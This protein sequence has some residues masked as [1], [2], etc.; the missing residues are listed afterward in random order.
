MKTNLR[1][2]VL[3]GGLLGLM[4]CAGCDQQSAKAQEVPARTDGTTPI[5][6]AAD[7]PKPADTKP[8]DARPAE[9]KPAAPVATPPGPLEAPA[10]PGTADTNLVQNPMAPDQLKLTPALADVIKLVQSGV[11]EEV[12]MTY[13]TNSTDIF[14]IGPNEILYLHDLGVPSPII[15][16]LIQQDSTPEAMARKQAANAVQPL[17]PGVALNKPAANVFPPKVGAVP[18]TAPAPETAEVITNEPPADAGPAPAV[19]YTVPTEVQQPVNVSYF[20]TELAPYG[21]WVD[22]PGYGRCWRP[23]VSVWNSAWRPYCDGGRWLWSDCGWYW[24]SDYTWGASTFH[25]GR[26]TC[27]PGHGWLWVPDTC[28]GPSWVSWRHTRSHCAW[29]P[30]PPS[31]HYVAGRGWYH[32]TLSVGSSSE[33]GLHKDAYVALPKSHML[34]RRPSNHYLSAR[35]AEAVINESSVANNY[36]TVNKT[37]VNHGI[38]IDTISKAAGGNIRQVS[39]HSADTVGPRSPR[40]ELL[41][42]DGRTL[43]VARPA[44]TARVITPPDKPITSLSNQRTRSEQRLGSTGPQTSTAS[45]AANN[46]GPRDTPATPSGPTVIPS[47]RAAA[48]IIMRGNGRASGAS[49]ATSVVGQPV[50]GQSAITPSSANNSAARQTA[51]QRAA[52]PA[53]RRPASETVEPPRTSGQPVVAKPTPMRPLAVPQPDRTTV[54]RTE[55]RVISQPGVQRGPGTAPVQPRVAPPAASG[56]GPVFRAA[57]SAPAAPTVSARVE[58]YRAPA[59]SPT[60]APRVSAPAQSSG[61]SRSSGDTGGG[62]RGSR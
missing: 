23:T 48:P 38:G 11:G 16:S 26:W 17:P 6:A 8:T 50:T 28:W 20:Y 58:S 31:A 18:A 35:H 30:L 3:S 10:V 24:Y 21:T 52:L 55:P 33:F 60:P 47:G 9:A 2:A 49:S 40:H 15:T 12:L 27:P 44:T 41:D 37:V 42:P 25:Y 59:P 62:Q 7:E 51:G 13:I 4:L 19:V 53:G 36:A 34:E 57:P 45:G 29:A 43:T 61:G 32:N 22:Y 1:V 5:L 54:A 46:L 39:I 56:S 14:N